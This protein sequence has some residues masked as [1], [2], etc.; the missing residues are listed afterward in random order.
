MNELQKYAEEKFSVA[1]E[2]LA[3]SNQDIRDRIYSAFLSFATIRPEEY[4]DA[5]LTEMHE[6]LVRRVQAT[7]AT[8]SDDHCSKLAERIL[9]IY[10]LLH[11]RKAIDDY[12]F[13]RA[14]ELEK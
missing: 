10:E 6:S 12:K 11:A 14:A 9:A 8:L 7:L 2:S 4:E 13:D 5:E 3:T 1:I